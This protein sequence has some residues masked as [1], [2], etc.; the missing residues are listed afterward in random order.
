M[1]TSVTKDYA[2]LAINKSLL[3][4]YNNSGE[5]VVY[6][7][8]GNEFQI[9][10]FNPLSVTI[11]ANISINGKDLSNRLIIKP[12]ER[13][14]LERYLDSPN[15]FLFS[16]Y[17]VNGNNS[18]VKEAIKNNGIVTIKFYKEKERHPIQIVSN[19]VCVYYD[20]T[21]TYPCTITGSIN[22]VDSSN[23]KNGLNSCVN[24]NTDYLNLIDS[25][26]NILSSSIT[27]ASASSATTAYY[28]AVSSD[29]IETATYVKP[30]KEKNIETGR[31]ERG[32]HSN[33]SFDY[34]NIDFEYWSFRTET[35][36]ILPKSQKQ[37]SS[38]DLEKKY[39]S[40]CGRKIKDKF[41]FCPFCGNKL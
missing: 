38:S 39:C 5:R 22:A 29:N 13:I 32:S 20:N 23:I 6:L 4:E 27:T 7:E 19:P 33:Q 28:S 40:E 3:K 8:D 25:D 14:W 36:H 12:G 26:S 30:K 41:K 37:Y 16:T 11:G 34:I 1:N 9:Q 31:I 35:I 15:K 21:Y 10:L 17:T 18:E 24:N 2:K